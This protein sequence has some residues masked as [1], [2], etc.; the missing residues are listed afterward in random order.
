MADYALMR[1]AV[2][3]S[4]PTVIGRYLFPLMLRN[5]SSDGFVF[6]DPTDSTRFSAP[7]C[8]IASPSFE[9]N[10]AA[11]RQNYVYNWTR[12]AAVTAIE[13]AA[14]DNP[15]APTG[16]SGPLEDYVGFADLCQ[17]NAPTLARACYTIEGRPRDWT[18]QNDGPA[19][20]SVA[21]LQAFDQLERTAQ[22]TARVVLQRNVDFLLEHYQQPSFNLWEE[23][24]GQSFFTR[25]VQLRCFTDVKGNQI[26]LPVPAGVDDAISWLEAALP[27]HWNGL[28][29]VSILDPENP[30]PGYDPNIDI[31]LACVYGAVGCA[32][33]RLLATAAELRQQWADPQGAAF[34][35][36]NGIDAGKGMGPL[37]GRYPGDIYDG[38]DNN[39][40]TDHPWA[41][42][43]A[44]FAQLYY[45]LAATVGQTGHIPI[46]EL[47]GRFFAQVGVD[48]TTAPADAVARLT[49]AGDR[50]LQAVVYHSDHLELSEQ[51]D[52]ATGY[53]K[54]VRNL[55]WSYAAFLSAARAR[56]AAAAAISPA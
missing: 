8:V 11:V 13:I 4:D 35:L 24:R 5:M 1:T 47:S 30:R 32:D 34:Y 14:A 50:M 36:I 19:L 43:T 27:T 15:V 6:T 53:E 21:I 17:R 31:V 56:T 29:Y 37:L 10:L 28:H 45:D 20:Q 44:N 33:P 49:G 38:D 55:T 7:G 23:T 3:S 41:L 48:D 18:D 51:F 42:C 52:G 26:G 40:G 25:S 39:S 2:H 22:E 16:G 9:R 54:S 12:D 46:D